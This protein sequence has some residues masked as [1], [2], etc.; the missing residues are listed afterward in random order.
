MKKLN[1]MNNIPK[2]I[3][4]IWSG[5]DEPLPE[6]LRILG[7]T[8]KKYHPD[9]SYEFWDNDRITSF[10]KQYYPN[11]WEVY[12]SFQY[13][14]QRWDAIR[15]LILD[16]IGG[17]YADFD[18]ECLASHN[19]LLE[20]KTCCFSMEP[21]EHAKPFKRELFFNNALMASIPGHPFMKI[22]VETV[23]QYKKPETVAET[24]KQRVVEIFNTTGPLVL[25]KLYDKYPDKDSIYL[26]PAKYVSPFTDDEITSLRRGYESKELEEKLQA[27]YS[28][29][30]FLNGWVE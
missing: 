21:K 9:W 17:I 3:H 6:H 1:T 13:N 18:T 2:L 19:D 8:W 7:E 5:V 23:F 14:I 4:Q 20:D 30:Y 24:W 15:Y 10:I 26:I 27:A 28:I 16:K 11:Y 25:V 22:I 12:C 29:H